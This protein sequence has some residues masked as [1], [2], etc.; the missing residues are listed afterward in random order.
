LPPLA[1]P[2]DGGSKNQLWAR[3]RRSSQGMT[4]SG[5]RCSWLYLARLK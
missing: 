1:A 4:L 2:Y 5:Q 3:D